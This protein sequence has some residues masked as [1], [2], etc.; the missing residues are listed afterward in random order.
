MYYCGQVIPETDG[1]YRHAIYLATDPRCTYNDTLGL[2]RSEIATKFGI[3]TYETVSYFVIR[4][5]QT[6][7]TQYE[8]MIVDM[9]EICDV[10]C[11][12]FCETVNRL[13]ECLGLDKDYR[14]AKLVEG[15]CKQ[16]I[17][18][19]ITCG[20][21]EIYAVDIPDPYDKSQYRVVAIHGGLPPERLL[22][23]CIQIVTDEVAQNYRKIFIKYLSDCYAINLKHARKQLRRKKVNKKFALRLVGLGKLDAALYK[24]AVE[25]GIFKPRL[26]SKIGK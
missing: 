12:D 17:V 2:Q 21:I 16:K 25:N 13:R 15:L 18:K 23:L 11:E 9:F 22:Q 19:M 1:L 8:N 5:I 26:L 20:D 14:M 6:N 7:F 3:S 4:S 10:D 24:S